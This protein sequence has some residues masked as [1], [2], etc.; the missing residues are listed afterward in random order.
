M[1]FNRTTISSLHALAMSVQP[2]IPASFVG[3]RDRFPGWVMVNRETTA[4]GERWLMRNGRGGLA[5]LH[6]DRDGMAHN[7]GIVVDDEARKLW[8][9]LVLQFRPNER[10]AL[11]EQLKPG[12]RLEP[13]L[14]RALGGGVLLQGVWLD[15]EVDHDGTR[16]RQLLV[17]NR[18][19][20]RAWVDRDDRIVR[21]E[22]VCGDEAWALVRPFIDP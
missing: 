12:D 11:H 10:S 6:I 2:P 15:D 5:W 4:D 8:P 17:H 13:A 20:V 22:L 21:A 9:R 14:E 18:G 19:L 3:D 7:Y 1:S 16:R